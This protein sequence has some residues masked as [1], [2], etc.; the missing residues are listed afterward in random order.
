MFEGY[1][2]RMFKMFLIIFSI[3][4]GGQL[5]IYWLIDKYTALNFPLTYRIILAI[6]VIVGYIWIINVRNAS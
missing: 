5:L 4:F 6:A 3:M 2:G 1:L